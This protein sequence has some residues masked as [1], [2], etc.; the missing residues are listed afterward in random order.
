MC[1]RD[2]F[3]NVLGSSGSVLP[4]FREQLRQGGPLTVTHPEMI[5]YFMMIPE[6][7]SLILQAY[8]IG[9][10]GQIFVLDMGKPV[11]ILDLAR[12]IIRQSGFTEKS[13]SNKNGDIE[14]IETGL[15]DGEKLYE[16]LLIDA[17]SKPTVHELIFCAS[18]KM[19]SFNAY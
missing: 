7:A 15:R 16:E 14:I 17:E 12:Q 19:I 10:G 4:L 8:T 11:K 6:A 18:E 3:G 13:E 1:I 2:S 9:Q 5:R